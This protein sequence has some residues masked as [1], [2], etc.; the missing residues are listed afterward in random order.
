MQKII[1]LPMCLIVMLLH[2]AH[3]GSQQQQTHT[4]TV[5]CL[6]FQVAPECGGKEAVVI[7]F[8]RCTAAA[9]AESIVFV[10]KINFMKHTISIHH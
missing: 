3:C 4:V 8:V 7:P 9:S 1:S 10:E 2:T 6:P 5:V